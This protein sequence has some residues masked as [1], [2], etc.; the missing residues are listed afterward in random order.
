VIP[1]PV[2]QF[3][4][5]IGFDQ[6][7]KIQIDSDNDDILVSMC[8]TGMPAGTATDVQNLKAGFNG[9]P[10]EIDGNHR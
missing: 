3:E 10:I 6:F 2:M 5:I 8:R 1:Q 9:K 4:S 7:L